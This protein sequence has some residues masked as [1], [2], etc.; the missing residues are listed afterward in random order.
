M[1]D[2]PIS[3]ILGMTMEKIRTMVD[4][5]TVV[6]TP[7][8]LEDG[9]T[10]VPISRVSFGFA[11]G[12]NDRTVPGGKTGVW[13]G[14]GAAIKTVP[15]GFLYIIGGTAKFISVDHP[16][17]SPAERLLDMA[18]DLIDKAESFIRK[19]MTRSEPAPQPEPPAAE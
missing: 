10:L 17:E 6:G 3:D 7:I 5:N 14:S 8:L 19:F 1:A 2:Q 12:G 18:P 11:S 4:A 15:V 9:S 13:G 16:E